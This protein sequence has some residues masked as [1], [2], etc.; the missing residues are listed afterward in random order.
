MAR[1]VFEELFSYRPRVGSTPAENFLTQAF[2]YILRTDRA[3]FTA[4]LGAM[5]R[6]RVEVVG[7]YSVETQLARGTEN[8]SGIP[9]MQIEATLAGERRMFVVSEH[10]WDAPVRAEQLQRYLRSLRRADVSRL[11]LIANT[12]ELP[13]DA[14]EVG[15]QFVA[16][17]WSDVYELLLPLSARGSTPLVG[18]FLQFLDANRMGKREALSTARLAAFT[19]GAPVLETCRDVAGLLARKKWPCVPSAMRPST[20]VAKK[21]QWGRIGIQF[22]DDWEKLP[23]LFLGF[24]VDPDDHGVLLCDPGRGFDVML[25]IDK[26]PKLEPDSAK[27]LRALRRVEKACGPAR[28]DG[29][30]DLRNKWRLLMIRNPVAD[31]IEAAKTLDGQVEALHTLLSEWCEALFD[32]GELERA[33]A[34]VY[35]KWKAGR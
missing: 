7:S 2:A 26:I 32:G 6:D 21:L 5:L 10:K 28:I 25:T 8:D 27:V 19:F 29:P 22:S 12:P 4:F 23:G 34:D 11:V 3:A 30:S 9:D 17:T 35:P 18:D 31:A 33:L 20:P 14:P 1:G 24:L 16:L 13:D 15:E